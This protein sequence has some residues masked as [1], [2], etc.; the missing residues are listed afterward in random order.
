MVDI[1]LRT[2][3]EGLCVENSKVGVLKLCIAR[4]LF[5]SSLSMS[6]KQSIREEEE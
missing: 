5:S 3:T 6:F 1:Q 2:G 4:W